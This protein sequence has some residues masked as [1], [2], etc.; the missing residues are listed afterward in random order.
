LEPLKKH[1][2]HGHSLDPLK[3]RKEIADVIWYC[4]ALANTLS[5]NLEEGLAENVAKLRARYPEGFSVA[6]SVNRKD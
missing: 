5:I 4:A 6:A 3:L 2:F 1:L